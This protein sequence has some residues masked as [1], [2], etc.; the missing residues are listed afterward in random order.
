[1]MQDADMVYINPQVVSSRVANAMLKNPH[2]YRLV[3]DPDVKGFDRQ[4]LHCMDGKARMLKPRSYA[5]GV[6][7]T[8]VREECTFIF[9]VPGPAG[10]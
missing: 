6:H 9:S 8:V 1:M 10:R 2:T 3:A 5:E 4:C 7:G